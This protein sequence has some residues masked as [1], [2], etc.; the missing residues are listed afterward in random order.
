[1]KGR[2]MHLRLVGRV[3]TC[4][5]AEGMKKKDESFEQ[6][7]CRT[8]QPRVRKRHRRCVCLKAEEEKSKVIWLE[9]ILWRAGGF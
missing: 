4:N 8:N 3:S 7:A 9:A 1:M 6:D 5:Q 2:C